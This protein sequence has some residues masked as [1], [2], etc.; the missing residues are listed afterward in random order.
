MVRLEGSLD[1]L[2]TRFAR[3]LAEYN[4]MQMKMKKRVT[5]LENRVL[6]E[7]DEDA[8]DTDEAEGGDPE[9]TVQIGE[10][11][12]AV[13][14]NKGEKDIGTSG[15]GGG[16][17]QNDND[18]T[19]IEDLD[20]SPTMVVTP[21]RTPGKSNPSSQSNSRELDEIRKSSTVNKTS[22]LPSSPPHDH[23]KSSVSS[24][25][26]SSLLAPQIN[27]TVRENRIKEKDSSNSG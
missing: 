20:C 8:E 11:E 22:N 2:Y 1:T 4:S 23:S 6:N 3:L 13:D 9:Q 18:G 12:N 19:R 21:P 7:E 5:R 15:G 27:P 17:M 10:A 14:L 24:S 25:S 16:L 26:E